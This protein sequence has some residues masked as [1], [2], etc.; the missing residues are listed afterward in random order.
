MGRVEDEAEEALCCLPQREE[1]GKNKLWC[2]KEREKKEWWLGG[3]FG[4]EMRK[5]LGNN[6]GNW[7][8]VGFGVRE[9]C[10][11]VGGCGCG[12]VGGGGWCEWAECVDLGDKRKCSINKRWIVCC[13]FEGGDT[14]YWWWCWWV[15]GG[16]ISHHLYLSQM[17][18][19][20][21]RNESFFKKRMFFNIT[22]FHVGFQCSS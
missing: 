21:D 1:S 8:N 2:E 17:I 4:K 11:L 18:G 15:I 10:L 9:L 16:Y 7:K 12:C 14:S 3:W 5:K 20:I 6:G 22:T 13:V 19:S